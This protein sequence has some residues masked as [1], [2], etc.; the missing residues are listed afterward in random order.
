MPGLTLKNIVPLAGYLLVQPAEAQQQTSSGI[1]LPS[2]GEEKPQL[3]SVV[4]VGADTTNE[5][6]VAVTA[7]VKKGDTVI[8]KKWGGN[9]VKLADGKE[10][11]LM[12]FEDI[13][14]QVK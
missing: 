7:P 14:A 12:K 5:H 2:A 3:G 10:V 1:Y 8:Y 9:E 4:A 13:I 11:Q 6:G